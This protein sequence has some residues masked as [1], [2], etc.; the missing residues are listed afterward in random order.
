MPMIYEGNPKHKEPWQPGAHGSLCPALPPKLP[1]WLLENSVAEP[2][3]NRR[4]AC[5]EGK[6]YRA[7]EHRPGF[8]HGYPV[9]WMEV[10][11]KIRR[12]WLREK[13]IRRQDIKMESEE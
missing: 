12:K 1:Q 7:S 8:W 2:G 10:P 11:E 4:F 6:A 5:H 3:G 9:S 13:C